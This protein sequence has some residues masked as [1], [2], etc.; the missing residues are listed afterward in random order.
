VGVGGGGGGRGC[1]GWLGVGGVWGERKN[2]PPQLSS[3]PSVTVSRWLHT[4]TGTAAGTASLEKKIFSGGKVEKLS[5][6]EGFDAQRSHRWPKS[7][8]GEQGSD[9]GRVTRQPALLIIVNCVVLA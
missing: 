7:G 2:E 8:K 1:G 4:V 9:W 6:K 5:D 3:S